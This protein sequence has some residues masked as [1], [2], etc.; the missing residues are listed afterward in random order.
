MDPTVLEIWV[1]L[2]TALGSLLIALA[3]LWAGKHATLQI[4]EWW[5]ILRAHNAKLLAAVDE[6]GD[7]TIQR[8]AQWSGVSGDVWAAFLPAFLRALADGLDQATDVPPS[9]E[10]SG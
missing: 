4:R 8:L 1:W 6:P 3:I 9:P 10:E 5:L 7:R 2:G